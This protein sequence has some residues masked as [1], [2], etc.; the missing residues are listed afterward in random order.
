MLS[1]D[2]GPQRFNQLLAGI[3]GISDRVLTERL[4][5]LESESV[6]VRAVD[7]VGPVRVTYYLTERGR[8]Y[9]GPLRDLEQLG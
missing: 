9:L 3:T 4:R 5:E 7:V 1:L 2:S 8:R 6:I